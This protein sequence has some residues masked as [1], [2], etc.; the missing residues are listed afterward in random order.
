MKAKGG[1]KKKKVIDYPVFITK[2]NLEGITDGLSGSSVATTGITHEDQHVL[3]PFS[4]N[5]HELHASILMLI[6]RTV[7][8][9]VAALLAAEHLLRQGLLR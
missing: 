1:K 3:G 9:I 6:V 5:L 7:T 4:S 2:F 8:L